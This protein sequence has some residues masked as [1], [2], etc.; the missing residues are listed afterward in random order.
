[1]AQGRSKTSVSSSCDTASSHAT[2][3]GLLEMLFA[4]ALAAVFAL[5]WHRARASGW[6][7]VAACAVYGPVRFM[8]DFLR[9]QDADGGDLRYAS[10]T[11]A[12]W[13]CI[14]LFG[15]ALALVLKVLRAR[16]PGAEASATTS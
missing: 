12:Q 14:G 4:I 11:P 3:S 15:F 8:L 9:L 6:Y 7:I 16:A 13:A 2:I 1:M 5:T 10:L